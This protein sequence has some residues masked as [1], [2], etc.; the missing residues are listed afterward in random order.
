MYL[1]KESSKQNIK[2][3]RRLNF[4]IIVVIKYRFI[5]YAVAS[6]VA[7]HLFSLHREFESFNVV[8]IQ[9]KKNK[10]VVPHFFIR[11]K[12]DAPS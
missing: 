7:V 4:N 3:L 8:F 9:N 5:W 10:N 6:C 1:V 12:A 11:H 2:I